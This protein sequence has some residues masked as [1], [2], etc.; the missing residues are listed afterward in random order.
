[1]PSRDSAVRIVVLAHDLLGTYG[2]L[3]NG[4]VLDARL[5]WRGYPSEL[6]VH[7]GGGPAPADADIYLLGGGEDAPQALAIDELRV[8]DALTRAADRNAVVLGVCA[9][10]QLLGQR[11]ATND[12]RRLP[13][14]GL[15]DVETVPGGNLLRAVGEIAVEP[16]PALG[17]P[18]LTGF[19]NHAGRTRLGPG[20]QPVGRVIAGFGNTGTDGTEG[21]FTGRV[22]GTYLHGPVLVRNPAL[23]DLLLSWVVGPL[24]PLSEPAVETLR[25]E[26]LAA[27]TP[28]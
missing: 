28:T 23:A 25:R 27:I 9:G 13:G 12:G 2:D 19:E 15:L 26:R 8:N 14:F 22:V 16:N 17:L 20:V 11:F 18:T 3:G 5:R 7:E 4:I 21:A 6:I 24:E 10:Y 1:M